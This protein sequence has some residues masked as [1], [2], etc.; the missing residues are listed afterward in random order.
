M[1]TGYL[2]AEL[3]AEGKKNYGVD[4][5]GPTRPEYRWQAR[6]KQGFGMQDFE[7]DWDR[8][9]VICPEGHESV[10]WTP[11]VDNHGN[12]DVRLKFSTSDC[13]LCPS[14]QLCAQSD[15]KYPRRY[16]TIRHRTADAPIRRRST[17]STSTSSTYADYST[18][19]RFASRRNPEHTPSHSSSGMDAK[20]SSI[21]AALS[22]RCSV[23]VRLPFSVSSMSAALL[24]RS[25]RS[26]VTNSPSRKRF[27]ILEVALCDILIWKVMSPTVT[28]RSSAPLIASKP[29]VLT[30]SRDSRTLWRAGQQR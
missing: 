2:D 9:K 13:G 29:S 3:L 23:R 16:L 7:I 19:N 18:R 4:L 8:K 11:F 30:A 5:Y 21:R 17:T 10:E 20:T 22:P 28:R 1:D 27:S 15:A 24:F 14:R 12:D 25:L 6:A 26:M